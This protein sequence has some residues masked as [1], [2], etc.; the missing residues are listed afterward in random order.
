MDDLIEKIIG[1]FIVTIYKSDNYMVSKFKTKEGQITVTGPSFDYDA[2]QK[3][4]LNGTY[5]D[6]PKYGH[7]FSILSIEKYLSDNKDEIISFLS[8]DL[9]TGIGKKVALK[10]YNYFG[11]DTL[12]KLKDN[13]SLIYELKDISK[14]Q[15]ES[16]IEG[17][18]SLNNPETNTIF[19]LI[20]NV[21]VILKLKRY[22]INLN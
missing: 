14:K 15:S 3:Y 5:I 8:S 11:D 22:L 9:F 18:E 21:L 4:V 1:V 12:K 19:H 6:H 17:F 16:I 2:R 13:P 10:I 20:S 7:Q